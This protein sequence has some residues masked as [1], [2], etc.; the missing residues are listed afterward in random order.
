MN[1]T[2]SYT[3]WNTATGEP[4]NGKGN[5]DCALDNWSGGKWN[6]AT[7]T[8]LKGFICER[9]S[10]PPPPS[11]VTYAAGNTNNARQNVFEFQVSMQAGQT[12]AVGTCNMSGALNGYP[13]NYVFLIDTYLRLINP[14]GIELA[15]ND[16]A[17]GN[18]GNGSK[19]SA[20]APTTGSYTIRAGCWSSVMCAGTIVYTIN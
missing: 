11:G 13:P 14:G 12:I 6:D 8:D 15:F 5:E 9:N 7:C 18:G 20:V 10:V 17:C 19:L 3:N 4:N 2:S 1:G 16:D